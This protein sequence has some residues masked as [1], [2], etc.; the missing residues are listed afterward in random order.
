MSQA[1]R[2]QSP[3]PGL[4]VTKLD[5]SINA[6]HLI[7]GWEVLAP[8]LKAAITGLRVQA[9]QLDQLFALL[10]QR[11]FMVANWQIVPNPTVQQVMD[12]RKA[13]CPTPHKVG[14]STRENA[15][16]N[17]RKMMRSA[18]RK[19]IC[20]RIY[21]CECGKWHMSSKPRPKDLI[22]LAELRVLARRARSDILTA[23][24]EYHDELPRV[25]KIT[26]RLFGEIHQPLVPPGPCWHHLHYHGLT[27]RF[28]YTGEI[29]LKTIKRFLV[30]SNPYT[31]LTVLADFDQLQQL[32]SL[33]RQYTRLS[34]VI[35]AAFF[36][37]DCEVAARQLGGNCWLLT[38][39]QTPR[40]ALLLVPRVLMPE[41]EGLAVPYVTPQQLPMFV[42]PLTQVKPSLLAQIAAASGDE[43]WLHRLREETSGRSKRATL[44]NWVAQQSTQLRSYQKQLAKLGFLRP[45]AEMQQDAQPAVRVLVD[46]PA[47]RHERAQQAARIAAAARRARAAADA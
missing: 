3:L 12:S 28:S 35:A 29:K 31:T 4:T 2:K 7:A 34:A 21:Q 27:H 47:A 20:T 16:K 14:W 33:G 43:K 24:L 39:V 41:L 25:A 15:Q 18:R 40:Q 42:L 22:T 32:V 11:R 37:H 6:Y 10:R 5:S 13:K 1:G 9:G 8:Y 30:A 46:T 36:P 26:H 17:L 44:K 23:R 19:T 45:Q 38:P